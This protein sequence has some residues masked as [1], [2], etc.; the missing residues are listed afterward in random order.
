MPKKRAGFPYET[1]K[2]KV[3]F[4]ARF[5]ANKHSLRLDEDEYIN[6]MSQAEFLQA[7]SDALAE[8]DED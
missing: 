5:S 6:H 2:D 7:I 8:E 4:S 1:L 3:L